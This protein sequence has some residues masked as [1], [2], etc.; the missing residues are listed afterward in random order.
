MDGKE[1]YEGDILHDDENYRWQVMSVD[2]GWV[3]ECL[4]MP[5]LQCLTMTKTKYYKIIGNI[6]ENPE[7]IK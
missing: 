1:I 2:G 3:I 7:L 4:E 6:Y 5:G